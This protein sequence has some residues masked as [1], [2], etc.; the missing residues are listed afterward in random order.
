MA[1]LVYSLNDKKEGGGSLELWHM[2]LFYSG[3]PDG[4]NCFRTDIQMESFYFTYVYAYD[5]APHEGSASWIVA[6]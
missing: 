1:L 6:T 2:F 3:A 4:Q 5:D